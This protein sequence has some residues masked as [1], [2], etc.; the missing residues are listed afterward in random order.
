MKPITRKRHNF[1]SIDAEPSLLGFGCMRLPLNSD[2]PSDIDEERA[3]EMLELAYQRGVNYFD[4]AYPYHGGA[5]EPFVGRVLSQ[6][7]RESY[8]LVSKLPSWEIESAEDAERIFFEQLERCGVEYFDFYLAHALN[9]RLLERY[10]EPGVM[11]FLERMKHEG[12]I[13]HLGFSFHDT[14]DVLKTILDFHPWDFVQ[15]QINYLDWDFQNARRQYRL[16]VE[17]NLPVIVM[18]PIRG[19]ALA[20]LNESAREILSNY[21]ARQSPASWALRYTASLENVLVVLSGMS[22]LDQTQENLETFT[23][24]SPLT[25]SEQRVLDEALE[26]FLQSR[27]IPCTDCGYCTP[28]PEGVDIPGVF[29]A[30]NE[31][32]ITE[33]EGAL[34][35]RIEKK[36]PNARPEACIACGVC[37]EHCPQGI[38]IPDE[39][40]RIEAFHHS[41]EEE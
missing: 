8:Y 36:D 16:A 37:L 28:C 12:R 15:L 20:R 2:D 21:D 38:D 17:Y 32:A 34:V 19:G 6:Y 1:P 39:L 40:K 31:Y 5:S 18:E 25:D 33:R 9:R 4:T 24:F 11:D 14:P 7:P 22:N 10:R 27:T 41:R 26:A 13:K 30:Y 29:R 35:G 3:T 23:D